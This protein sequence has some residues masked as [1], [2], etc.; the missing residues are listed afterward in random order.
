MNY[1]YYA[2]QVVSFG[3]NKVTIEELREFW[4]TPSYKVVWFDKEGNLCR[5]IVKESEIS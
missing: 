4:R 2:G 1:K 5:A 3:N